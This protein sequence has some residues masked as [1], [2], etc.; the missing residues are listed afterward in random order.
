MPNAFS[1]RRLKWWQPCRRK[2]P[3][4]RNLAAATL[5]DAHALD[6]DTSLV[7][8]VLRAALR[9]VN[10][11]NGTM[12]NLVVMLGPAWVVICDELSAPI[13]VLN[14]RA[15][16]NTPTSQALAAYAAIGEPTYLSVRQLL[17]TPPTFSHERVGP[18]V[19]ICEKPECCGC[20][21]A[22]ARGKS[23]PLV[24]IE[25]NRAPQHASC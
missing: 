22:A 10:A 5:G 15:S 12:Y 9:S 14:L 1:P 20:G 4:W 7:R 8:L 13:L 21:R 11:K 17:R 19:Y 16:E 6:P 23:Q 3:H 18:V 24:C 2:T 25:G